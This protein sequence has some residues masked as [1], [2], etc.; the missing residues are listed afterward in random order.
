MDALTATTA[1]GKVPARAWQTLFI[2]SV[3]MFLVAMDV[4]IVSVALPG[5]TKSFDDTPPTT[6]AWVFTAYNIT[7]AALLL[8]AGKLGDRWGRKRTFLWGL[9]LFAVA[10]LIAAIAPYAGVLIGARVLQA[11]GSALLYPASLALLLPEFP[12]E[13]RSMAIGVWG[14]IAGLGGAVAPT[15]GALL[16]ELAGWRAVFFINLPFV[17]GAL[18]FG[19][20][21]LRESK[22]DDAGERFDPISVPIAAVAIGLLVLGVVQGQPWGWNDPKTIAAFVGAVLLLPVFFVRSARHPR[23]LLDLNLFRIRSFSVANLAQVL[24]TGS[25]FGWLVLFPSFFVDVWGWSPLAAGFGLAPS[26]ALS[27]LLSPVAGRLADRVGHRWLV[28]I[29]CA[30]GAAGTTWWVVMATDHA[31]YPRDILPGM[32]LAGLGTTAGFATLTGALMSRVPPRYYSM[33]GAAR[34][35]LFQLGTAIGIAVAVAVVDSGDGTTVAPYKIVWWIATISAILAGLLM[36]TLF[37]RTSI[38]Q[39]TAVDAPLEPVTAH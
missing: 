1:S 14:G 16:V 18:I 3:S 2:T 10:S 34:S 12:L 17:I 37:P 25:A 38:R 29:G 15:I 13:R 32:I 19:A 30:C 27:A 21:I 6:L 11:V 9:V 28:A 20:R 33:G 5:I 22:I 4:T 36:I 7:F 8:L 26:A 35:T 24:F 23:P 39:E 31:D